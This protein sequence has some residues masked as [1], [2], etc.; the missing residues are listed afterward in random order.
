MH[1]RLAAREDG[2]WGS[3]MIKLPLGIQIFRTIIEGGYIYA[4]KTNYVYSLI[5]GAKYNFLSRP[6]R[7][8]KSLLLDTIA[9]TFGG[10]KELFKS[11]YI[12]Y[13]DYNFAK[14]PVLRLDMSNISNDDPKTLKESLI[15]ELRTIIKNEDLKTI[16]NIAS[17]MFK[18]LIKHIFEK[19][20]KTVVV[21]IDEYDKP[22]LDHIDDIEV[23][24]ANRKVLKGFYGILKSMD[25]YLRFT[26]ITGVT[27]YTKTSI[28]SELNNLFDITLA[29]DY[30][31]ICGITK[32]DLNKYFVDYIA[33]IAKLNNQK[34]IEIYDNILTWYDGYSWDGVT[35]VIN[36]FSLLSFFT[37]KRFSNFWYAS[38]TPAFLTKLI[39]E[40]PS[41]FLSLDNLKISERALDTFDITKMSAVPLLFQTGYLTISE[42]IYH[43][44]SINYLLRMPNYE[45]KEAFNIN[46][47]A[48]L[49]GFPKSQ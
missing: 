48:E 9:E 40:K 24:E 22:I 39:K 34:Y 27:K 7:F 18:E 30:A 46:I 43:G 32:E 4:D 10:D 29:K 16:S 25:P 33:G 20:G 42:L 17:D 2:M 35:S 49:N 44:F 3:N 12:Y 1:D 23:A 19:Y 15:N 36:P 5:N 28:F 37:Q 26:F 31:N 14:H 8:G 38:G 45:V 13:T 47:I 21:L 41:A 11:L 6:R